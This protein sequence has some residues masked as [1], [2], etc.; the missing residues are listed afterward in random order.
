MV[1]KTNLKDYNFSTINCYFEYIVE[2]FINGQFS[3]V[4]DLHNKLSSKQKVEFREHCFQLGNYSDDPYMNTLSYV[5]G[6]GFK[7]LNLNS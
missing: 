3:Q 7:S 4:R 1:T 5:N 2:S 6:M